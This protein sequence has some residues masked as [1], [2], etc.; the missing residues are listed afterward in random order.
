MNKVTC[1]IITPLHNKGAYVARTI[2]SV[3]S[4]SHVDWELIV[5]ENGSSDHGPEVVR[6]FDDKRIQLILAP[7]NVRGPGAARNLG[8][9]HANG[10]W[11]LFLDADDILKPD[12]L[13]VLLNVANE[14]RN[15]NIVVGGWQEFTEHDSTMIAGRINRPQ[16]EEAVSE[17]L[18]YA[19]C[20]P[21][22]GI[23]AAIV[24]RDLAQQTDWDESMDKLLG[25]DICFWFQICQD[26]HVAFSG[27]CS[28]M[29]RVEIQDCRTK[30]SDIEPW[31]AGIDGGVR[32][33]LDFLKEKG[34]EISNA[35]LEMLVR[36]YES[37]YV[38]AI[39]QNNSDI[40]KKCLWL[41]DDWLRQR[42]ARDGKPNGMMHLRKVLGIPLYQ[43][44]KS[45]SNRL[46]TFSR[47]AKF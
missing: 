38:Q 7:D 19:L 32:R 17:L 9:D 34:V 18:A 40:A 13:S 28:A 8:L 20:H 26:A 23:H 44:V 14:N 42:H 3:L 6:K 1:S 37:L 12:H 22:W 24:K 21:P 16:G 25:E 11:V 15:A 27:S 47:T 33:N 36:C 31:F 4:Q 41:A 39:D 35:Q 30:K 46:K 45:F 5:T 43:R 29:Y 10:E 2:E